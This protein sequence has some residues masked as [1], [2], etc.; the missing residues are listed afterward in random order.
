MQD[1]EAGGGS[2]KEKQEGGEGAKR[3]SEKQEG[4]AGYGGAR[5][6]RRMEKKE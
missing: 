6:W 4:K 5:R 3:R 1:G 2:R